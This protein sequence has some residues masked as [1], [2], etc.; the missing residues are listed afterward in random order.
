MSFDLSSI[1]RETATRA[2]KGIVYGPPGVGK[3]TFGASTGGV[4][5]DTENGIPQ[6]LDVLH[7]PYL[8]SWP[9]I[10]SCL[11]SILSVQDKPQAIV[12]DTVDWMLRRIEEHVAGTDGSTKGMNETLN[13]SH[14]GYGNGQAVLKNYVYQYL[15]PT[16]DKLTVA[17]VAI[18]LLA[19]TERRELTTQDGATFERSMP[20]LHK[21]VSNAVIEWS[22]FIGAACMQ[23]G[24]RTL[25][26]QE[27]GQLIAKNRYGITNP[28]P[29]DWNSLV[30]AI[31]ARGY[32]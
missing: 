30:S 7:T 23:A 21:V 4:V 27:T 14:K 19:H 20:Q 26:L 31:Q 12:V 9:K 3:T 10:E 11:S 25:V 5:V 8:D 32:K 1:T 13:L 16:L 29:L 6:G 15:L 17:G 22:D 28:V 2:P 24:Q 18:V